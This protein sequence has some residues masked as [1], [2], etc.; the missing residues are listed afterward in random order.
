MESPKEFD[1]DSQSDP[2]AH[3]ETSNSF[4]LSLL[5][6]VKTIVFVWVEEQ[7]F[8]YLSKIRTLV[9]DI[10]KSPSESP[11]TYLG[12]CYYQNSAQKYYQTSIQFP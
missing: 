11:F 8:L 12:P 1:Y 3:V 6:Y 9:T 7:I 4:P 5:L 10:L 2:F